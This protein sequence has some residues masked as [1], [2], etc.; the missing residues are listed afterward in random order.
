M[1]SLREEYGKWSI[2]ARLHLIGSK[3]TL[4]EAVGSAVLF[5]LIL[6][7]KGVLQGGGPPQECVALGSA[8]SKTGS[9]KT[10]PFIS[11]DHYALYLSHINLGQLLR[12]VISFVWG[13]VL[14]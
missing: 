7:S 10:Y 11:V 8:T 4:L 12:L 2:A 3:S 6:M 14:D 13:G 5:A 9:T 1:E